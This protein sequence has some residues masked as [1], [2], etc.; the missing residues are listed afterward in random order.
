MP[1]PTRWFSTLRR[2]GRAAT[3]TIP[4]VLLA[5]AAM[6]AG[7]TQYPLTIHNCGADI[8]FDKPP[9]RVVSIGQSNTE[10]LYSLGLADK[11]VGTAVWFEP[12]LP[13]YAAADAKIK[14]LADNDPSFESVVGQ[15]P[16]LVTAQYEWHIGPHGSV[17]KREQ[18]T[19]LKIPTYIAPADCVEKDNSGGGDGVRLHM[20]NMGLIY[21]EIHDFAAIFNVNDRGD[22]LVAELQRREAG[23]I[24]AVAG[25]KAKNIPVLF[26]FSSREVKGDAFVAGKNGAPAYILSTLGDRNVITT[27]DE[28]PTLSWEAITA[29]NP[30][31]IVVA[32]MDR[33]RFPADDIDV[34]LNF[35]HTDPV[36]SQL[37]AVRKNRIVIMGAQSMNPTIRTIDGIEALAQGIQ[38]FGLAQ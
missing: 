29:A 27:N 35:L 38:S 8:T 12:V 15:E 33:R 21:Q 10:I 26:W 34:K 22:A 20:F 31:V 16:D 28:W 6:A 11:V 17:G 32:R 18:F 14:R 36:V 7:P 19:A 9:S 1:I 37:E 25:A 3:L 13:Q 5:Q 4:A 30:A 2:F 23:A 24:A